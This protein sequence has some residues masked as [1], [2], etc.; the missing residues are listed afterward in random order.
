MYAAYSTVINEHNFGL[1]C[2]AAVICTSSS[3][4]ALHLLRHL[5]T[6]AGRAWWVALAGAS[7]STGFGIW[8]THFVVLLAFSRGIPAGHDALFTF[9]SLPTAVVLSG[10]GLVVATKLRFAGHAWVGGAMVGGSIAATHAI[11]MAG[12]EIAGRLVWN[13]ILVVVSIAIG[14]FLAAVALPVGLRAGSLKPRVS[15]ASLLAAAVSIHHFVA[16]GAVA[17]VPALTFTPVD[18]ALPPGLLAVAIAFASF[19]VLVITLQAVA[20]ARRGR[21]LEI[22]QTELERVDAQYAGATAEIE[23]LRE[24]AKAIATESQAKSAFVA[25]LSHEIRTSLNAVLGLTGALLDTNLDADQ[26]RS[27]QTIHDA[28]DGLVSILND[29]LDFSRLNSGRVSFEQIAFSPEEPSHSA[30]AMIAVRAQTKDLAVRVVNDPLL[31]EVLLGDASR[32]RQV[33]LNLVTNAVKFTER[34]EVVIATHCE[35][36]DDSRATIAWSVTDTGIG[37]AP[38]RLDGLFKEFV[39]ADSSI[40]RRYGGSGLGLAICKRLVEQMGGEIHAFSAVGRGSRFQFT[41]TL[42]LGQATTAPQS[43]DT[44]C[45]EFVRQIEALGRPLRILIADD[46]PTNRMVVAE[47]FKSFDCRIETAVNGADAVKIALQFSPD[48][49]LMDVRMPEMDGLQATRA[50]RARGGDFAA[51]PIIAFTAD[52]FAGDMNA[53]LQAGMT[54]FVAKPVRKK[55]LVAAILRSIRQSEHEAADPISEAEQAASGLA[56][57]AT[58]G[59]LL[60]DEE[61]LQDLIAEIGEEAAGESFDIF[62]A[63]TEH[64]LKLL[65]Q[66]SCAADRPR[67][68]HEAHSLR[69][70]AVQFGLRGLSRL[71]EY[72]EKE[73]ARIAAADYYA[74]LDRLDA[75]FAVSRTQFPLRARIAA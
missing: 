65:R 34:G 60:V 51:V 2:L 31:P 35:R 13:P 56:L 33:L 66:L 54:D 48:V 5:Q 7:I 47:M 43:Q 21:Q 14:G 22:K 58:D 27:V 18:N 71:A 38:E 72:L 67:I 9:L 12:L 49:I 42:P 15:G 44:A 16:M 61:V 46:Q 1:V 45:D 32:I 50:L 17:V 70:S 69:G 68:E 37:I 30:A 29:I 75:D 20:I 28:G 62:V 63:D 3:I 26:R 23:L 25:T 11:S 41:L 57:G 73:A 36:R 40:S 8:A 52:A 6:S 19:S 74:L 10:G 24:R 55:T 59:G 53:G 64:R 39:Q 4:I